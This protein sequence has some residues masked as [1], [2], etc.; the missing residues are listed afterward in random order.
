MRNPHLGYAA[1]F[2][3]ELDQHLGREE[4]APGRNPDRLERLALEQLT[5]AV[6][7]PNS[8]AEEDAVGQPV[9][10]GVPAPDERVGTLEAVADHHVG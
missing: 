5:G 2:E 9:D 6:D 1:A 8:H 10:A 4:G 7:V 3:A